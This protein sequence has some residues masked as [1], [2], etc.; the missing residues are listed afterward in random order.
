MNTLPEV[1]AEFAALSTVSEDQFETALATAL[2]DFDAAVAALP[3]GTAVPTTVSL[4]QNLS[5]G[6][7][8]EFDPKV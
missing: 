7:S 4:T 2:T 3:T 5:D 6:T 8:V 1:R